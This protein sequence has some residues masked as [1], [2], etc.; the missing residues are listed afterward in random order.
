MSVDPDLIATWAE[1][2]AITRGVAPP[3]PYRGGHH[4]GVGAPDQRARY[5]FP[6]LDAALL[7]ELGRTITE[8][9]TYL[10]VCAPPEAVRPLLPAQWQ[11][12]TPPTYMMAADLAPAPVELPDGHRLTIEP[13][14]KMLVASIRA[15]NLVVARGRLVIMDR[16]AVL[17]QIVT[18]EGHRRRGLGRAIMTA[19][20]NAALESG[21]PFGFLSATEMGRALY[22]TLGW[23]VVSP[24]ASAVIP[25]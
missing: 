11:I 14:G 18:D 1:A 16:M 21:M 20:A 3:V 24:Y 19:L 9:W 17:D 8:P 7:T 23:R 12:R 5:V 25:A 10:K 4:I 13:D 15:D 6:A 22:E 2:W